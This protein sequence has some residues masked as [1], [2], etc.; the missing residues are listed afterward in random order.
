MNVEEAKT[1]GNDEER[2]VLIGEIFRILRLLHSKER[3]RER[4]NYLLTYSIHSFSF[5]FKY[6]K[7]K[8]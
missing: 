1:N 2:E 5:I 6:F 4:E 3:E 8:I 7:D